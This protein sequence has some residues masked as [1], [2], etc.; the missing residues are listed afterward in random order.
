[1]QLSEVKWIK[2]IAPRESSVDKSALRIK[3][4]QA[5][6]SEIW[7][8]ICRAKKAFIKRLDA[9]ATVLFLIPLSLREHNLKIY[10]E[11]NEL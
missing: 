3:S 10:M 4:F 1:M 9:L 11:D 6:I 7:P 2:T 5:V 8:R